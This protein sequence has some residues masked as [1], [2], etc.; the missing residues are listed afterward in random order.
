MMEHFN[1]ELFDHPPYSPDL[2]PSDY[3]LFTRTYLKNWLGSQNFNNNEE[4]LEGVKMWLSSQAADF[5]D[6][7]I[8]KLILRYDK[9]LNSSSDYGEKQFRYV[10][11]FSI[12]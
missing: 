7:G 2:A 12:Q 4:L 3:Q 11:T 5:F 6:R 9:C 8:Q 1:W 10:H